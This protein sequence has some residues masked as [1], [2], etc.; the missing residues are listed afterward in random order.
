[1]WKEGRPKRLL[2]GGGLEIGEE[3]E[4]KT[5]QDKGITGVRI[6]ERS[7]RGRGGDRH[8]GVGYKTLSSKIYS[9]K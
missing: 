7:L 9:C 4:L 8:L 1:M 2:G 3:V 6:F 5:F